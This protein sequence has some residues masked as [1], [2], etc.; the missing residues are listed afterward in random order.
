MPFNKV[1]FE[2]M[3]TFKVCMFLLKLKCN[4]E[5]KIMHNIYI[6]NDVICQNVFLQ[7]FLILKLT[8]FSFR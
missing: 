7:K 8:F 1:R 6:T 5:K 4:C 2:V 3:R